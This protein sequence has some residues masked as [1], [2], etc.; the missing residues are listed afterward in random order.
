V[1]KRDQRKLRWIIEGNPCDLRER[2]TTIGGFMHRAIPFTSEE[3]ES[4]DSE[5]S[6]STQGDP[7]H[8]PDTPRLVACL[9]LVPED[10]QAILS[11]LR[12]LAVAGR[13][14]PPHTP[15][16]DGNTST[17]SASEDSW[18]GHSEAAAYLGVSKSTLYHYSSGEQIE[19]R[20]LGGRLEY[21]RSA[22]D[23]FKEAHTL[24][25]NCRST[26]ARIIAS[27]HSS[28]K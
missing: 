9:L 26:S 2:L 7:R 12:K 17:R 14:L 4:H 22:L 28:G 18:L 13:D 21:R 27:A 25:A 16:I 5:R 10:A 19:R 1:I 15:T 6:G 20:K 24:Q 8:G 3:N 23:E 11:F